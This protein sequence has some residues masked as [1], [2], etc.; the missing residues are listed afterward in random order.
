MQMN[1]NFNSEIDFKLVVWNGQYLK[2][3]KQG[4][5]QTLSFFKNFVKRVLV[6]I[7]KW[8]KIRF[9][10]KIGLKSSALWLVHF[11]CIIFKIVC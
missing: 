9:R 4:P 1:L 7:I 3:I 2:I 5:F 10:F 8:I 11:S 6:R